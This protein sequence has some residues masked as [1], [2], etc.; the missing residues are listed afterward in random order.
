M[1]TS[2]VKWFNNAK[3]FGFIHGEIDEGDIFVHHTTI[4][5]EGYK[6]LHTGQEVQ[7]TSQAKD[8]G[9]LFTDRLIPI[10]SDKPE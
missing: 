8:N 1:K 2:T 4:E 3:G 5:M 10:P 9:Q 7:F 6:T